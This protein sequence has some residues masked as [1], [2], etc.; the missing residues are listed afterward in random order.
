MKILIVQS[1]DCIRSSSW[2]IPAL[3]AIAAVL[4][5]FMSVALDRPVMIWLM[6]ARNLRFTGG[7]EGASAGLG[8]FVATFLYCLVVLLTIRRAEEVAFVP[9]VSATLGVLLAIASAGVLIYHIHQVS[10]SMQANE[11]VTR[12]SRELFAEIDRLFPGHI[13]RASPRV[14]AASPEV[15]FL[16]TFDRSAAGGSA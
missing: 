15:Q 4:L 1:W 12:V 16:D 10:V 8:T 7:A 3:L 13:G 14:P 11:V 5:A 9:H 2:F 6:R